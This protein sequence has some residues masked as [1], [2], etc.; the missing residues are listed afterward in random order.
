MG[1]LE[2]PA[3]QVGPTK[4]GQTQDP[5]GKFGVSLSCPCD[6]LAA[7]ETSW[8]V[9]SVD[10]Q[11][12]DRTYFSQALCQSTADT[13]G[14]WKDSNIDHTTGVIISKPDEYDRGNHRA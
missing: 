10:Y 5:R 8:L 4:E 14:F 6:M 9:P 13:A 7:V 11:G 2:T 1:I 3:P 12:L